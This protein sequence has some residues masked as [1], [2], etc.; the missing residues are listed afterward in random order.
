MHSA[1]SDDGVIAFS[2]APVAQMALILTRLPCSEAAVEMAF[3]QLRLG[4]DRFASDMLVGV[5]S[6]PE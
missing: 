1:N 6:H 4:G 5:Q 2:D 3:Y